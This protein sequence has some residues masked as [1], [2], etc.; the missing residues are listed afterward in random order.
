MISYFACTTASKIP[1]SFNWKNL[2]SLLD[3]FYKL[4]LRDKEVIGVAITRPQ[5]TSIEKYQRELESHQNYSFVKML[6]LVLH[7]Q[8]AITGKQIQPSL[9]LIESTSYRQHASFRQNRT[10]R[11]SS[12]F[13]CQHHSNFHQSRWLSVPAALNHQGIRDRAGHGDRG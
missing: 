2:F 9:T 1:F 4:T 13:M 12:D 3:S 11:R 7:L 8:K 6:I 10:S 5:H